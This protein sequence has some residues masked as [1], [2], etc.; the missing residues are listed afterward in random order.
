MRCKNSIFVKMF[1][2]G[3]LIL[4]LMLASTVSA[5]GQYDLDHF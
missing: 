5:F 4:V 2:K 3:A 1:K